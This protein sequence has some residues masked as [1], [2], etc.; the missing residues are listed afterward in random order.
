MTESSDLVSKLPRWKT[1]LRQLLVYRWDG[2]YHF[3][4]NWQERIS[5]IS[6][7]GVASTNAEEFNSAPTVEFD[8]GSSDHRP[9][10]VDV[11]CCPDSSHCALER[12]YNDTIIV[13][14]LIILEQSHVRNDISRLIESKRNYCSGNFL[15]IGG[16]LYPVARLYFRF[17]LNFAL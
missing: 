5:S 12:L 15:K 4:H 8:L 11:V 1:P 14:H 2:S 9:V 16:N 10:F 7:T 13:F 6:S 17:T 3:H